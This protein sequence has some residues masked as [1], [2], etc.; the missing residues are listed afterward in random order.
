[1]GS[2]GMMRESGRERG[3][4][5]AKKMWRGIYSW[6][7]SEGRQEMRQ[8]EGRYVG[9]KKEKSQKRKGLWSGKEQRERELRRER[10]LKE[11]IE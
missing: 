5:E 7:V 10:M 9:G 4:N 6:R 8:K 3:G 1:M 2:E 11:D